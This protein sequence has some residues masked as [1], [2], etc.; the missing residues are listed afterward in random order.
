MKNYYEEQP[1]NPKRIEVRNNI[2]YKV[3][4]IWEA[5]VLHSR[6]YLHG[7]E[8]YPFDIDTNPGLIDGEDPMKGLDMERVREILPDF[9]P[10][11]FEKIGVCH[12]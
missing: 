9:Q 8:K 12:E 11:P 10:I 7:Y 3:D 4:R 6:H 1:E 2:Y 5:Y